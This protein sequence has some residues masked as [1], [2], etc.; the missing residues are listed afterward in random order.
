MVSIVVTCYNYARYLSACLE[1]IAKQTYRD[2]EVI[3]VDDGS[4][5]DTEAVARK[6]L[7]DPRLKIRYVKQVNA[8]QASAK[9]HGIRLA[10][11]EFIA[12][13]DADDTWV[14]SKLEKQLPLFDGDGMGVVY[15]RGDQMDAEGRSLPPHPA[16]GPWAPHKG[17]LTEYLI[18]ENIVPFSSVVA[19]KE[20]FEKVGCF[21]EHLAMAIDW[22]LWLRVSLHYQFDFVDEVLFHYRVGHADQ[23]SKNLSVRHRCCDRIMEEFLAAHPH[24]LPPATIRKARGYTALAR[25]AYY[26]SRDRRT[27]LSYFFRSL[28][29]EPFQLRPLW[30]MIRSML[31]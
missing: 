27:A 30:G 29:Y 31:P 6:W 5:D 26:T 7:D 8:G 14:D 10:A 22:D 24:A 1:S 3:L 9:N 28:K 2:F 11:G 20:V 18:F 12:F 19:R 16:V 23:M 13:L 15:S 4:T 17:N 21:K 25:G